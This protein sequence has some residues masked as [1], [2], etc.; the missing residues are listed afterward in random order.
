MLTTLADLGSEGRQ[1]QTV[2]LVLS[3]VS[4]DPRVAASDASPLEVV[5]TET[6]GNTW[7]ESKVALYEQT[8]MTEEMGNT[9]HSSNW[10]QICRQFTLIGFKGNTFKASKAVWRP[11]RRQVGRSWSFGPMTGVHTAKLRCY[12]GEAPDPFLMAGDGLPC[13]SV[14]GAA[15]GALRGPSACPSPFDI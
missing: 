11:L 4:I 13:Q 1:R 7:W 14:C 8:M 3:F 6:R 12:I 10:K 2:D 15:I 5:R 9:C